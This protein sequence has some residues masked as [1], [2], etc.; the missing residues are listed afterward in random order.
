MAAALSFCGVVRFELG[1]SCGER[2]SPYR[3]RSA[4]RTIPRS[5]DGL[6][7]RDNRRVARLLSKRYIE[8]VDGARFVAEC[9]NGAKLHVIGDSGGDEELEAAIARKLAPESSA[10]GA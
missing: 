4:S 8:D 7:S 10:A 6:A 3:Q 9:E 1:R 2:R 5:G